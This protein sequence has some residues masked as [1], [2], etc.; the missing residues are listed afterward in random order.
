MWQSGKL[1]AAQGFVRMPYLVTVIDK[2]ATA[3]AAEV[4]RVV[5]YISSQCV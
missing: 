5:E 2:F 4:C 1:D 3:D